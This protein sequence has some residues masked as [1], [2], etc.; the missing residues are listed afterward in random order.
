MV[1]PKLVGLLCDAD[2][3][4]FASKVVLG[5]SRLL[6]KQILLVLH[7]DL[8]ALLQSELGV[9]AV[10]ALQVNLTTRTTHFQLDFKHVFRVYFF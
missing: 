8:R 6:R 5:N 7:A 3:L 10:D 2:L 1:N 4:L 9:L